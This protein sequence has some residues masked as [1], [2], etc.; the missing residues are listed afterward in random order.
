MLEDNFIFEF[1]KKE[2]YITNLYNFSMP[3]IRYTMNDILEPKKDTQN[4]L[5]YT[6]IENLLARE[7]YIPY[8][9]NQKGELDYL[10]PIPLIGLHA[11]NLSRY[12]ILVQSKSSFVLKVIYEDQITN[13][14]KEKCNQKLTK[15]LNAILE[16]KQM[17]N[18]SFKIQE[19]SEL[20]VDPKTGKF[21]MIVKE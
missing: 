18:V 6:L 11:E 15:Q 20:P 17:S 12:Q 2:T 14:E 19:A 21:K 8:F 16:H 1:N 10:H 13:L 9:E 7:E 5:P 4:L 3:M